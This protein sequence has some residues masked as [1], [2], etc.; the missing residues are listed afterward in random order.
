MDEAAIPRRLTALTDATRD[1]LE[2]LESAEAP[3]QR[4]KDLGRLHTRFGVLRQVEASHLEPLLMSQA[5]TRALALSCQKARGRV[6]PLFDELDRIGVSDPRFERVL[7]RFAE[8]LRKLLDRTRELVSGL[9]GVLSV[10]HQRL[11]AE[12]LDQAEPALS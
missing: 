6:R 5:Q 1:A 8:A 2:D 12:V 11:L 4:R 7:S 9:G 3:E 10:E